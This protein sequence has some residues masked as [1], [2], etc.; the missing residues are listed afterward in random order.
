M[1]EAV[2][3]GRLGGER[4]R[5]LKMSRR[6]LRLLEREKDPL[7]EAWLWTHRSRLLQS[8]GRGDGRAEMD[9]AQQLLR[10]LPP[11]RVHA[12][13]LHAAAA[14]AMLHEPGPEALTAAEQAVE[15]AHMV[16]AVDIELNAR[17]TLGGLTVDAG[18]TEAG[19]ARM[20]AVK[21]QA[22]AENCPYLACRAYINLAAELEAVGRSR[23]AVA[24]LE[25]GLSHAREYGYVDSEAWMWANLADSLYSLGRWEESG[26][27]ADSALRL[28]QGSKQRGIAA[29]VRASLALGQ[30]EL[31]EAARQ[32]NAART[33]F[34][35]HDAM[36]QQTLRLAALEV[37]VAAGEGRILDAR[38]TLAKVLRSEFPPGT[39]HLAW[40]LL[41]TATL[42][43]SGARAL[44]VARQGRAEILHDIFEVARKLTV[45]SPVR[46]AQE[47]W[48]RAELRHAQGDFASGDPVGTWSEL[49]TALEGLERPYD[50]ARVRYR[51][52]EA[53]LAQ[54]AGGDERDR[55]AEL[56]R[57]A[58]AA[59]AELGAGP[60]AE[61]VTSLVRRAR[62]TPAAAPRPDSRPQDTH[63]LTN[64]ERDVL[65]LVAAGRS[66]RQIAEELFISPKTAS[67]H[68]SNILAKLEVAGRGEAAALAHRLGLLET[69]GSH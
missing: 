61:S 23:E 69:E 2:T 26:R 65:R 21:E 40:P 33:H 12:D 32:L 50:L 60:L 8:Q 39:Q 37:G 43:E 25:E 14:W 49:V 63:G 31:G 57:L 20:R 45:D 22:L 47:K 18:D 35:P 11:S 4:D 17:L 52:A 67:V 24:L 13:V 54:G 7:L 6:A 56:L 42:A 59:A 28:T 68:V 51:L 9:T 64:R 29:L 15:Y 46:A 27:A 19:L 5:A 1:A 62:L 44:P 48:V 55:A 58:G 53:L 34:G 16:G 36:P 30:G 41:L 10:G 38:S 66:N 3:A